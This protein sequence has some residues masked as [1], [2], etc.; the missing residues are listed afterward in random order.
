MLTA[1]P[2]AGVARDQ[3]PADEEGPRRPRPGIGR[4]RN[5]G[6]LARLCR[7]V[8]CAR[9]PSASKHAEETRRTRK[10]EDRSLVALLINPDRSHADLARGC[11]FFF[12]A[13]AAGST[14]RSPA[15]QRRCHPEK[16]T[17]LTADNQVMRKPNLALNAE[18]ES[19]GRAANGT[20][21]N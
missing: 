7:S 4:P 2:T 14:G 10:D 8:S 13:S 15:T 9:S 16:A 21:N 6:H 18:I 20:G 19:S 5:S 1:A 3:E 11:E 12:E 17:Y